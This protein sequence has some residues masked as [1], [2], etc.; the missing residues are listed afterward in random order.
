MRKN[1]SKKYDAASRGLSAT[2]QLLVL[3]EAIRILW[4]LHA[5]LATGPTT[6]VSVRL[7]L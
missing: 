2:A 1:I 5:K 4:T 7:L 3:L 6:T